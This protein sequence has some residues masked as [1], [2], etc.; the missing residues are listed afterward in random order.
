MQSASTTYWICY[1][2]ANASEAESYQDVNAEAQAFMAVLRQHQNLLY[3]IIRTYAPD[4]EAWADLEQE[5][6]LQ[7]WRAYPNYNGSVAQST[8]VYRIAFNVTVTDY[9]K[10]RKQR[11]GHKDYVAFFH[12]AN[13]C[14]VE[15][16][17]QRKKLYACIRALPP[18]DRSIVLLHLD[19]H[20]YE[21]IS[22]IVGISASNVGTRLS[23]IR[24]KLTEQLKTDT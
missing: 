19:G 17:E 16:E 21:R 2:T 20:N 4:R 6:I 7:L 14:N 3:Q 11:E 10:R 1:L 12:R 22:E 15:K 5:I 23:R 18:R 9:R 13:P 8:W 24:Q